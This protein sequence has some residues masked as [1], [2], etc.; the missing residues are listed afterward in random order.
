M[1][2]SSSRGSAPDFYTLTP[3]YPTAADGIQR[4]SWLINKGPSPSFDV[5]CGFFD[6][7]LKERN[8]E[9]RRAMIGRIIEEW[10]KRVGPDV[11]PLFRLMLPDVSNL[12]TS[13]YGSSLKP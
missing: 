2:S 1:P 12:T 4:P 7:I 8:H 9:R 3:E 13:R 5:L 10:R 11:Y 6:K